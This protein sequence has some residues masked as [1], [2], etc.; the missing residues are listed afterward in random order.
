M[1]NTQ[2]PKGKWTPEVIQHMLDRLSP[3][4]WSLREDGQIEP[5]KGTWMPM[6]A[7][8]RRQSDGEFIICAPE[9]ITQLLQERQE[10]RAALLEVSNKLDQAHELLTDGYPEPADRRILQALALIGTAL[11]GGEQV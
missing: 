2:K 1:T 3:L 11:R 8:A 6:V 4:P 7:S 9:I 5:R 10:L